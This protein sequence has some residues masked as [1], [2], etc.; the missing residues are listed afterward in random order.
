[1]PITLAVE[2]ETVGME[3]LA[4]SGDA[5]S[6]QHSRELNASSTLISPAQL[7]Q[8]KEALFLELAGLKLGDFAHDWGYSTP[9]GA[10]RL[11][12]SLGTLQI[13]ID[14]QPSA[15]KL[16]AEIG[17]SQA[18]NIE[19]RI[20]CN[21]EETS[22][23]RSALGLVS[24]LAAEQLKTNLELNLDSGKARFSVILTEPQV[25]KAAMELIDT[26]ALFTSLQ[27]H[28]S[29]TLLQDRVLN[30]LKD[31]NIQEGSKSVPYIPFFALHQAEILTQ[32]L[33]ETLNLPAGSEMNNALRD[34][35]GQIELSK[36]NRADPQQ[37]A[38]RK[39]H[40]DFMGAIYERDEQ[41]ASQIIMAVISRAQ[42]LQRQVHIKVLSE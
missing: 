20:S 16:R 34:L 13:Q 38:A 14:D 26:L 36:P 3:K 32:K 8:A 40:D 42:Q 23:G 1:M 4:T 6:T 12:K 29:K 19:L 33:A 17:R 31:S 2:V 25:G 27:E 5:E 15:V 11:Q 28:I 7:P 35:Y 18:G 39:N 10:P 30:N 41:S 24:F 22:E 37:A 21:A 9:N